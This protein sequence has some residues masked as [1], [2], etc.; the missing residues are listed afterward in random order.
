MSIAPVPPTSGTTLRVRIAEGAYFPTTPF[1]AVVCP[2][3][4]LPLVPN[5]E[6][7]R[8]TAIVGDELTIVRQQEGTNVRTILSGDQFYQGITEKFISDLF[9][10]MTPGPPGPAGPTGPA[11]PQGPAGPAGPATSVGDASYWV[12][13]GHAGLTNERI[14]SNLANGY[15]KSTAGE[16]STVAAIP[17]ADGGTGGSSASDARTNLG[18]GTMAVQN[19]HAVA[20]TGGTIAAASISSAG[21]ITA[22]GN[23]SAFAFVG[24]GSNLTGLNASAL[25]F[26]QVAPARLGSG[27][28]NAGTYLRGDGTWAPV[29]GEFAVGLMALSFGPCP[30]GYTRIGGID[31]HFL[32]VGGSPGSTGGTNTHQHG[33]G[34]YHANRHSHNGSVNITISGNTAGGGSHQHGYGGTL[35]GTTNF[36]NAGSMNVDAGGS[37]F[38]ARANHGH[39]FAANFSGT[40]DPGGDHQH[41]FSGSG[42]GPIGD[43]EPPVWG[44]SDPADH[45]PI[46]IQVNLCRKD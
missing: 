42:S 44:Q 3:G 40:T 31:G 21:A 45:V 32:R 19:A 39:D 33:P 26:G 12:V 7:V 27:A 15:V 4:T 25:A 46:H 2:A 22:A 11:G 1:N 10:A 13:G 38:M 43:D 5:A 23:I 8:V 6:I 37:G 36:E 28:A 41:G 18:L 16:P 14:L 24:D 30:P 35:N 9:A 29:P 20:I 17:V 34:N